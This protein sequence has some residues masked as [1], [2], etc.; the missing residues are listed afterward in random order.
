MLQLITLYI[1]FNFMGRNLKHYL[2]FPLAPFHNLKWHIVLKKSLICSKWNYFHSLVFKH[3]TIQ[4]GNCLFCIITK[5][6]RMWTI[7]FSVPCWFHMASIKRNYELIER[8]KMLGKP[9]MLRDL[10]IGSVSG[11]YVYM[12]KSWTEF[13][14]GVWTSW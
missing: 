12:D 9:I 11:G 10:S 4:R 2:S 6:I 1:L 3:W 14:G 7:F 13:H 8:N 5:A